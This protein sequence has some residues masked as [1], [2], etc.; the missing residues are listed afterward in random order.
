MRKFAYFIHSHKKAKLIWYLQLLTCGKT[1]L[2]LNVLTFWTINRTK[3][4]TIWLEDFQMVSGWA[5]MQQ[6]SQ[7]W[8]WCFMNGSLGWWL[9][10]FWEVKWRLSGSREVGRGTGVFRSGLKSLNSGA[11]GLNIECS[12]DWSGQNGI[13]MYIYLQYNQSGELSGAK[14]RTKKTPPLLSHDYVCPRIQWRRSG[15][16]VYSKRN[17][18]WLSWFC[19]LRLQMWGC[20]HVGTLK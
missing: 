4:F 15:K 8:K 7:G 20:V 3:S 16:V 5:E 17:L 10:A 19:L 14:K 18:L 6:A 1:F 11:T 2:F 13:D 12:T 9:K